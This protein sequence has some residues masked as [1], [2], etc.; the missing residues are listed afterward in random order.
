MYIKTVV[1]TRRDIKRPISLEAPKISPVAYLNC[2]EATAATAEPAIIPPIIPRIPVIFMAKNPIIDV[3][4]ND[5]TSN[6]MFID[7][8]NNLPV[9]S[10]NGFE[11]VAQVIRLVFAAISEIKSTKNIKPAG[12]ALIAENVITATIKKSEMPPVP[13]IMSRITWIFLSW[14]P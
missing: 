2:F 8:I 9:P 10:G 5:S 6:F 7:S 13:T 3:K 4:M 14:S 11:N 1:I 12:T